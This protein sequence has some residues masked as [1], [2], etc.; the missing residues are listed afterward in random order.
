MPNRVKRCRR[1]AAR[2]VAGLPAINPINPG[3]QRVTFINPRSGRDL[4]IQ[5]IGTTP[6]GFEVYIVRNGVNIITQ[7]PGQFGTI[8]IEADQA[9]IW[10]GPAPEGQE[11]QRGPNGEYIESNQQPLEVYLEGNVIVRQDQ[12][13]WAGRSD[14]RTLRAPQVYYNFLTD[15]FVAHQA[16][17]DL[18]APG[19]IAPMRV[20]SPKIEQYH[21]LIKQ[22]D[23]TFKPDEEPKIRADQAITTGSR[24][25]NPGYQIYQKSIDLTRSARPSTDPI[26]GQHLTNPGDPNPPKDM[27]WTLDARQNIYLHGAVPGVLLAPRRHR[28]R[29]R[30]A[31]LPPVLLP[32]QQLFRPAVAHGLEHLPVPPLQEARL[33]RPLELRRRLP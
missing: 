22:P 15:R 8:D 10:R 5:Q 29:R 17:I 26:S 7:A 4:D 31:G 16:E 1:P 13:K 24:F 19:L 30:A 20:K 28:S 18:F 27:V 33:G 21:E 14:Q 12:R 6:D 2:A 9:V 23:G 25:P 11:G 3:S 32:D